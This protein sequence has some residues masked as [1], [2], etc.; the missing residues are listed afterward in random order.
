MTDNTENLVI[1]HLKAIRNEL[2]DFRNRFDDE[3]DDIK[4]RISGLETAMVS[5]KREVNYGDEVDARQQV[6]LDRI[7]KRLDRLERRLDLTS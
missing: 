2:R 7:L 6:S 5:V 4:T 1:E 3:M